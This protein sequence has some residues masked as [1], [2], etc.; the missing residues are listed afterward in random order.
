MSVASAEQAVH[1][2]ETAT[3]DTAGWERVC[4]LRDLLVERGAAALVGGVQVALFRLP[5]DTVR[6]VQQRDPYSGANVMSRGIVGTRG[7]VPT[8]A[9]P[10]YKQVFDLATGRCL[11][12][13][14]YVPVQGLAPDLATWPVE[15]RDGVVHVGA[16]PRVV[17]EAAGTEGQ[18]G[19]P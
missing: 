3:S 18:D 17:A 14:G 10:M 4:L 8:V 15:V 9:G 6:V 5:D 13:A 19:A 2:G 16:R 7:G 12:A 1:P 11:E